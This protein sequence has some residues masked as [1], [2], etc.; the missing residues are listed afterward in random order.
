MSED[1]CLMCKRNLIPSNS[2]T[3]FNN[4]TIAV[5]KSIEQGI[6]RPNQNILEIGPGNFRNAFYIL[7]TI[8]KCNYFAFD[9]QDTLKR[10]SNNL[11]KY[12]ALGGKIINED[13]SSLKYDVIICTFVIETICP[14]KERYSLINFIKSRLSENG[15]LIAS[16]RGYDGVFG[17]KYKNCPIG[18]G[19]ISTLKTFIKPFSISE[20]KSL[21]SNFKLGEIK[22]L[23]KYKV[24]KPKNI[25]FLI[26]REE[27]IN[28]T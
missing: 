19:L 6:I 4:P 20:I 3:N 12:K 28:G 23:Q 9:L 18:E 1:I 15:L 5:K 21:F 24:D 2:A 25:H 13:L 14:T 22:F 8:E 26:S 7:N 10:F 11:E 27:G 16:F 17:T